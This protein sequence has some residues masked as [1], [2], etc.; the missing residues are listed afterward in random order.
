MKKNQVDFL[1]G[2]LVTYDYRSL[3]TS[4]GL[5]T[6]MGVCIA[7]EH[8]AEK[9]KTIILWTRY[10]GKRECECPFIQEHHSDFIRKLP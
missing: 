2:D 8:H 9:E 3:R 4:Q 10:W 6:D 5:C 7:L 1:P